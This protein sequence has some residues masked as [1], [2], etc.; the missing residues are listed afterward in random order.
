MALEDYLDD[1]WRVDGANIV[2][3]KTAI[4]EGEVR[5]YVFTHK[6]GYG[7]HEVTIAETALPG[8]ILRYLSHMDEAHYGSSLSPSNL[9]EIE[10]K[11]IRVGVVH[12]TSYLE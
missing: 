2:P 3:S 1:L 6:P 9:V 8:A 12:D 10:E 11:P 4:P 5:L 7:M